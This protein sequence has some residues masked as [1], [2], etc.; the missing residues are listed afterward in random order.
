MATDLNSESLF[1]GIVLAAGL[2]SRMKTWKPGKL[3]NGVPLV[4]HSIRSMLVHC[5]KI[6]VVGGYNFDKLKNIIN[7]VNTFSKSEKEKILLI[8]NKDYLSGMFS[9]VKMGL[10][11]LNNYSGVFILPGDMPF[12]KSSTYLKLINDFDADN[13]YDIFI[14]AMNTGMNTGENRIQKGHPVLIRNNILERIASHSN[15]TSLR[16]VLKEFSSKICF[17]NDEG[18]I[19][20]IDNEDDFNKISPTLI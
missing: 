4:V 11:Y 20:D 3:V 5:S 1:E 14:P 12:V 2:S 6:I 16:S 13:E 7:D 8:E 10:A 18:I 19:F 17:V 9:S 15:D